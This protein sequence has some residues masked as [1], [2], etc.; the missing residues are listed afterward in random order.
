MV[1][2]KIL[3]R[4]L[5]WTLPTPEEEYR[6]DPESYYYLYGEEDIPKPVLE[7]KESASHEFIPFLDYAHTIEQE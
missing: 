7:K 1:L 4:I 6:M 2:R 5:D 3:V